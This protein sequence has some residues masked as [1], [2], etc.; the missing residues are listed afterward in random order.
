[1]RV[2]IRRALRGAA[3]AGAC[4][5]AACQHV[6]PGAR[7]ADGAE[8]PDVPRRGFPLRVAAMIPK[9]PVTLTSSDGKG[10]A[11]TRLSARAVLE[12]PLAFTEMH[13]VFANPTGRTL[14]GTFAIALPQ[15]A[16]IS[17]FAMRMGDR[18]QEGEVVEKQRA[19]TAFEDFLHVRRD[20]ALLEQSAGNEFRARVFPIPANWTKE[21]VVSYAQEL[22]GAEPYVLPLRGLP[23]IDAVDLSATED[24]AN[25]SLA[26]RHED[27]WAPDQDFVVPRASVAAPD[28]LRSDGVVLA[29]VH[30]QVDDTP[31]PVASAVVPVDTSASRALDLDAQAQL[32]GALAA[33]VGEAEGAA[34]TVA[35]FDQGVDETFSGPAR[36]FGPADVERIR[37]RAALGASDLARA[38][39]W[40]G[41]RARATGAR[42]VIVVSD[43]VATA[44]ETDRAKLVARVR[45]LHGA[46]VERLDTIGV[47]GI[48]DDGVLA[49]MARGADAR[50]D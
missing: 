41:E 5:L 7:S 31:D 25:V 11:L 16:S 22:R 42:R 35:C 48:R 39:A 24:G 9:A 18:W 40:A 45:A 27:A 19:R 37:A 49:S 38:L 30:P 10:L 47:G 26:A 1:M 28:A 44:G 4:A 3:I 6:G 50:R 2:I 36:A 43:G 34:L 29:R 8:R 32:V 20:P 46:G 23:Q 33:R 13:L 15:R 12:G 21:I 17:R 14:E